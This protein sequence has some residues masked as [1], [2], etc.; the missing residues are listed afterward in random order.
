MG[1][2]DLPL[3]ALLNECRQQTDMVDVCMGQKNEIDLGG[4]D[5]PHVNRNG[6][7]TPL[8]DSAVDED[9]PAPNLH[10]PART[11][12]ADLPA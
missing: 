3:E 12:N 9:V 7:V 6:F 2:D 5:R 8:G 1:A 4:L 11:G 10:Q